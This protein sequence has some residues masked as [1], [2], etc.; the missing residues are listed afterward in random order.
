MHLKSHIANAA[1]AAASARP[2]PKRSPSS[3]SARASFLRHPSVRS[4]GRSLRPRAAATALQSWP[5]SRQFRF[6]KRHLRYS[7]TFTSV[8][9]TRRHLWGGRVSHME[10]TARGKTQVPSSDSVNSPISRGRTGAPRG[11]TGI[12]TKGQTGRGSRTRG[13]TYPRRPPRS[14]RRSSCRKSPSTPTAD[15]CGSRR[16]VGMGDAGGILV[17]ESVR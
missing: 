16:H 12:W 2:P 4:S 5:N 13:C 3:S 17:D 6:K 8:G 11:D 10:N 7:S 9:W 1:A 15:R 14:P